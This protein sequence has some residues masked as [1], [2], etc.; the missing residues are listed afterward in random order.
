MSSPISFKEIFNP[1]FKDLKQ[2]TNEQVN[3]IFGDEAVFQKLWKLELFTFKTTNNEF[4]IGFGE[5]NA[6]HDHDRWLFYRPDNDS[7]W[8]VNGFE[9]CIPS[10]SSLEPASLKSYNETREH[11]SPVSY[12]LDNDQL[13]KE[14][15][16]LQKSV[17]WTRKR[18]SSLEYIGPEYVITTQRLHLDK[19]LKTKTLKALNSESISPKDLHD[20]ICHKKR[21]YLNHPEYSSIPLNYV[22]EMYG[23]DHSLKVVA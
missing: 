8:F 18:D 22:K 11:N 9:E 10:P 21:F 17:E 19:G 16:A 23:V 1:D 7:N 5:D 14:L 20:L 12:S 3:E 13:V 4:F 15:M 2:Q 6:I